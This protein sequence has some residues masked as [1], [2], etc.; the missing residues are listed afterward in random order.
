MG[1]GG[2]VLGLI[3][4]LIGAGGLGFGFVAW[5][6]LTTIENNNIEMQALLDYLE[7]INNATQTRLDYL[8]NLNV[9]QGINGAWYN[10]TYGPFTPATTFLEI[11]NL[12]VKFTLESNASIYLSFTCRA[13]IFPSSGHS[14]VFFYFKVDGERIIEPSAQ[15]GNYFGGSLGDSFSV[16]LQH[17]IEN[18]GAGSHNV[19]MAVYTINPVNYLNEMSIFVQSFSP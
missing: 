19:T 18:M 17:F 13:A 1:K 9:T 10:E 5:S 15:V 4:I 6:S 8:E 12:I 7:S 14:R 3:G 11:S 2:A 16:N